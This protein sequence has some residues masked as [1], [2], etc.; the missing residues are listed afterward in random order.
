MK[1]LTAAWDSVGSSKSAVIASLAKRRNGSKIYKQI[2]TPFERCRPAV[3]LALS[4]NSSLKVHIYC[5]NS[6]VAALVKYAIII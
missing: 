3:E 1:R 6:Y 4:L 5:A 2:I